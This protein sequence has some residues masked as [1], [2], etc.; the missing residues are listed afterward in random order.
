MTLCVATWKQCHIYKDLETLWQ[1][2]LKKNPD[3]LLA[4]NNMG[5][6]IEN[7]GDKEKAMSYYR[8]ALEIHINDEV[9]L[10]N[11]GT[12]LKSEGKLDEAVSYYQKAIKI[13]PNYAMAHNNLANT[14]KMQGK[15]DEAIEYYKKALLIQP[16]D[17]ITHYNL[18]NTLR[19]RGQLD[20]AITLYERAVELNPRFVSARINY[21]ITMESAGRIQ[22]AISQYRKVLEFD[23]NALDA[24]TAL[25]ELLVG[26]SDP[27]IRNVNESVRY[28]EHAAELTNYSDP[29]VLRTLGQAYAAV[30]DMNEAMKIAQIALDLAIATDDNSSADSIREWIETHKQSN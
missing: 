16:R 4:W 17:A 15:V 27:N 28:A 14:L 13:Q 26:S 10:Y 8:K 25:A 6:I 9:S 1:D 24:T 22:E 2:T 20:Q 5:I 21:A 23:P 7:R 30:G 11:I 29:S 12:L 3:S 18:A 19:S